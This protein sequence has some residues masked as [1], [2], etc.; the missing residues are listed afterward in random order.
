[1][2]SFDKVFIWIDDERNIDFTRVPKGVE[3]VHVKSYKEAIKELQFFINSNSKL[4]V[5]FDH[6]LGCKKTGYDIAKWIISSGYSN[7][8]FKIHS[9]NPVGVKNIREILNHYCYDEI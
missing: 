1:M 7:I 4:I 3:V 6:D 5:D 9:M 8:Q 2:N